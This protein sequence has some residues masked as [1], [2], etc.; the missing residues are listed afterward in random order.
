MFLAVHGIDLK[1]LIPLFFVLS[2][3]VFG[4]VDFRKIGGFVLLCFKKIDLNFF[5]L[6]TQ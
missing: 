4:W 6:F 2:N 5:S 1:I 3:T